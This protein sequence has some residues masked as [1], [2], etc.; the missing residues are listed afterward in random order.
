[1]DSLEH[2]VRLGIHLE[3][4]YLVIP[5]VND[6]EADEVIDA[7]ARLCPVSPHPNDPNHL[8]SLSGIP[9]LGASLVS[10]PTG[11]GA[12]ALTVASCPR[13]PPPLLGR[14]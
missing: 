12:R 7:V 4:T 14:I 1:M 13:L 10:F 5:G 9:I 2:A 3:V 6:D 11:L 8:S